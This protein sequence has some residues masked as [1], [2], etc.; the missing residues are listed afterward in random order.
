M[1]AQIKK[2]I[3]IMKMINHHYVVGVKDVFATSAKIFIVLVPPYIHTYIYTYIH[4]FFF[5]FRNLLVVENSLIKLRMK[6]NLA[7]YALHTHSYLNFFLLFLKIVC[8]YVC[9]IRQDST[10]GSLWKGTQYIPLH[11]YIQYIHT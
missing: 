6:E 4:I 9:R 1:G 7:K 2:E 10:F 3:S 5:K 8:M 11:T